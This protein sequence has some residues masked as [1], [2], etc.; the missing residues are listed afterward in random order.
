[1]TEFIKDSVKDSKQRKIVY[2]NSVLRADYLFKAIDGVA[3]YLYKQGVRKGDSVII[4][5]PNIPQG[6]IALYA[7][8]K[9]GAIA[10][11]VHPKIGVDALLKIA[12][13]SRTEW[14]FT[15]AM[16]YREM[17]KD[18]EKNGI[19]AIICNILTYAISKPAVSKQF[20]KV[21]KKGVKVRFTDALCK[22]EPIPVETNGADTAIYLH[23]SGTTGAPKTVI[24]SNYALNELALNIKNKY[25][26]K[27]PAAK[28]GDGM[29]MILPLFHGFGL[30]VCVHLMM[31][32]G[33]TVMVP[34]F[35]GK[36]AVKAMRAHKPQLICCVPNMLRKMIATKGFEGE[37][38]SATLKIFVGGDKLDD[39]LWEQVNEI[40]S[41][42]GEGECVQGFGLSETASVTHIN[43]ERKK[44]GTV[45]QP[46]DNVQVKIKENGK[47]VANG[48]IG[49]IYICSTSV[50]DGYLGEEESSLETDENGKVWLNTGDRGYLGDDGS[51]YYKG[52]R[53]RMLKIG[54]VNIFPQEVEDAANSVKEVTNSCAVRTAINGK[55]CIKLL[56]VLN[57]GVKLN[58]SL[59]QKICDAVRKKILPYAV[60][61]SIMQVSELRLTGMG[62]TDYRYYEEEE[63]K[64]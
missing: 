33:H 56:V 26:E 48:E 5:L 54:G 59:R 13:E 31:H 41:R 27:T 12:K 50:M 53:K 46:L 19:N 35:R 23:S 15:Y 22:P 51:L 29:L 20:R 45:G 57:D 30:G 43:F 63:S 9:I 3:T 47:E 11:V 61:R 42:Y 36:S 24:L 16:S 6:I 64:K 4:C 58:N 28:I 34:A 14:I 38:L 60:P 52:R 32:F 2:F 44:G 49:D 62:K 1:M 18:L 17:D 55:P 10:N 25:F 40:L 8:N 39:S 7:I 37:H 21:E